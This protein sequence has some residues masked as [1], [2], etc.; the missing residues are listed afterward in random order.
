MYFV[1]TRYIVLYSIPLH[2]R[3]VNP[4][5]FPYYDCLQYVAFRIC[6]IFPP[7]I[8]RVMSDVTKVE[9]DEGVFFFFFFLP[10]CQTRSYR[11]W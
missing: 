5:Y 1:A 10:C 6:P 11:T 7:Q 9:G 4:F 8:T 2:I 3:S